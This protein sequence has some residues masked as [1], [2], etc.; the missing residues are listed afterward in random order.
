[1][2][3]W[4]FHQITFP[5]SGEAREAGLGP[6]TEVS[7]VSSDEGYQEFL[8]VGL[9]AYNNLPR[10]AQPLASWG[11]ELGRGRRL[12]YVSGK[13]PTNPELSSPQPNQGP[14]SLANAS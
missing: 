8:S 13:L 14:D 9:A 10:R 5:L 3:A 7:W 6:S 2:Q 4:D 11:G 1:M 12:W